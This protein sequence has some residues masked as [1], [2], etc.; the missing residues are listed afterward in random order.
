MVDLVD[1][2]T[3]NGD[4]RRAAG[5]AALNGAQPRGD[6]TRLLERARQGDARAIDALLP[7]VYR[8]LRAMAARQLR[9]E[10]PDHTLT[11]T[12]LVHET[13]LSLVGGQQIAWENRAHFFTTA[14]TVIRRVLLQHA[15]R[16]RRIKRGGKWRRHPLDDC[17]AV[18]TGG[19]DLLDLDA[20]LTRLGDVAPQ[21]LRVVELRFFA[22]LSV[23]EAA[24]ALGVSPRTIARDWRFAKAW[25][26]CA[27]DG[28][29]MCDV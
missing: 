14:A 2:V 19:V 21:K 23:E 10:R 29:P 26:R 22:G 28:E 3:T 6:V 11:P 18:D 16:R 7:V 20:A 1:N 24:E 12:A 5:F 13:Y 27:L 15:R 8:E 4:G 9:G 17:L 25:L